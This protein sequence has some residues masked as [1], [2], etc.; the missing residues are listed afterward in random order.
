MLAVGLTVT[1]S[2]A[3]ISCSGMPVAESIMW[4]I[5]LLRYFALGLFISLDE[6]FAC[7]QGVS[8]RQLRMWASLARTM[9]EQGCSPMQA[10]A[11]SWNQV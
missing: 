5:V 7:R 9:V 4:G 1:G 11:H 8:K 6:M 10:L 3:Y 2:E